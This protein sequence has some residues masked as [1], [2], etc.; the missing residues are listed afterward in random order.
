[1]N[2][3]NYNFSKELENLIKSI[4]AYHPNFRKKEE[5]ELRVVYEFGK[6]SHQGQK[7]ASGEHFFSHG[8]EATKILLSILPDLETIYACLLH[9]VIEQTDVTAE[10]LEEKFGPKV[11]FLCEGV[12]KISQVKLLKKHDSSQHFENIQKLFVAVSQD[13]RVIFVKLADRIHNLRTIQY[14][15]K[16]KGDRIALE[17]QN[18]YA[19]VA[20]K[21][22]LFRFKNEIED[23]C[24]KQLQPSIF[25]QLQQEIT[26]LKKEKLESIE[27][28]KQ[29][30]LDVFA[31]SKLKI[32]EIH[33]R[34][35]NIAS[36]YSKMKQKNLTSVSEIYDLLGFR[37][38]VENNEDCYQ[39]LG[40]LHS[41][42]NPIPNRFKDYIAIAKSNGYR[43]LHTTLLGVG[44]NEIPTEIQIRTVEM[45][46]DAKFGP[47]SHWAYKKTGHSHF[48]PDYIKRMSWFPQE[49][50]LQEKSSPEKFFEEISTSVFADRIYALTPK[51]D[52]ENLPLGSTPVDFA[53]A[54]HSNVGN[55]CIGAKVNGVIKP[56]DYQIKNGEIIE[57]LTKKGRKPNPAW[58][59]FV[60]SPSA[61]NH[62]KLEINKDRINQTEAPTEITK[63]SLLAEARKK[64]VHGSL[65]QNQKDHGL[66]IIIGG[67]R[68][69]P[70]RLANC[71]KPRHGQSIVGYKSRG[72]V[73]TIHREQC[74]HLNRLNPARF[75]EASFF[76]E[77][78]IEIH[79]F[80]RI[81]LSRDYTTIVANHGLNFIREFGLKHYYDKNNRRLVTWKFVVESNSPSELNRLLEALEKINNVFSVK[82]IKPTSTLTRSKIS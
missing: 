56:L 1:M 18:I 12:K 31:K 78:V 32:V 26:N 13:I 67:E 42:W 72:L 54:I 58:L 51:G 30:I 70:Y 20:A 44:G 41:A 8:V 40:I 55:N 2:P 25:K 60:K 3:Q 37:V 73:F 34:Q 33:G 47:A 64:R 80:D 71:C 28:S 29:A 9:D 53:Y 22:G 27:K 68:N 66:N 36:V 69:I 19:P 11:R 81:G 38:I 21:L 43:S 14:L 7:R 79:A 35:K 75:L 46:I 10:E 61:R 17:S 39:A 45:N 48:D 50:M 49:L 52:I 74:K 57:I 82:H 15:P 23:L 6:K 59:N 63:S 5:E 62:I 16:E 76:A 65:H 4:Q 24:L 77:N